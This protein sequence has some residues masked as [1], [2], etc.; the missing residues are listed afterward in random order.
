MVVAMVMPKR[1]SYGQAMGLLASF[2]HVVGPEVSISQENTN[3]TSQSQWAFTLR[4]I[5][6]VT[7]TRP[8]IT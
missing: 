1:L 4:V 5:N 8:R 3:M 6:S 7:L 2:S